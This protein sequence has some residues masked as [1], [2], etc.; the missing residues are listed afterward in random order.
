MLGERT[1]NDSVDHLKDETTRE[2]EYSES[3]SLQT[4][5]L[6]AVFRIAKRLSVFVVIW[7]EAE[8]CKKVSYLEVFS[9]VSSDIWKEPSRQRIESIHHRS[10]PS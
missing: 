6:I 5:P 10:N 9:P 7:T 2:S 4:I 8:I 1:R 3:D